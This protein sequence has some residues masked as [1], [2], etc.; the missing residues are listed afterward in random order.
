MFYNFHAHKSAERDHAD[1]DQGQNGADHQHHHENED[2]GAYGRDHLAD[3]LLEGG[4]DGVH[5]VGDAA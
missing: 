4:V 2:H 1:A 5:V 3:A